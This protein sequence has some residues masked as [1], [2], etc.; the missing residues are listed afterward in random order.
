MLLCAERE[1]LNVVNVTKYFPGW[2]FCLRG[3]WNCET[4][5]HET[6]Q[7]GTRSNRGVEAGA[8]NIFRLCRLCSKQQ[9]LRTQLED[10]DFCRGVADVGDNGFALIFATNT[11]LE[12]LSSAMQL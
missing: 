7:R 6:W 11:Q 8:A 10:S 3:R 4:W 1:Y 9:S 12:L 5:H 2:M